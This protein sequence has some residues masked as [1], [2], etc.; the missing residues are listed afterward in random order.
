MDIT[1][2][3]SSAKVKEWME[4]YLHSP[5][6]P[7]WHGAQLKHRDNFNLPLPLL[8]LHNCHA[9]EPAHSTV[10]T[11]ENDPVHILKN[12][13]CKTYVHTAPSFSWSSK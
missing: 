3:P 10:L 2:A 4:L 11:Q 9:K 8:E 13:I 5:N 12:C 1:G 6:M 7:S